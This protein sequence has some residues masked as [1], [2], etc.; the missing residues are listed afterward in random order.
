MPKYKSLIVFG[1]GS[2]YNHS[3]TP[4]VNYVLMHHNSDK[5]DRLYILYIM[6]KEILIKMK[7]V[8]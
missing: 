7:N 6:L 3:D 8:K 4:N 1:Y 2:M 5:P